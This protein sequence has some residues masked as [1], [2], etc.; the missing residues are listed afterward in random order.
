MHAPP[1]IH[2]Y[3]PVTGVSLELPVG[4]EAGP[5]DEVSVCYQSRDADDEQVI[6]AVVVSV[7]ARVA[8]PEA[9]SVVDAVVAATGE[10]AA[11]VLDRREQL[12]DDTRVITVRTVAPQTLPG[13]DRL[14][15]LSAVAFGGAV[16]TIS[17]SAPLADREFWQ[18]VFEDL[19]SSCR[20]I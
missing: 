8:E 16:R 19:V 11:Q 7:L 1:L 5:A 2:F 6:A 17:A 14:V 10:A 18:P 15:Q 4:F 20:F 9:D 3:S 13:Q 12:V